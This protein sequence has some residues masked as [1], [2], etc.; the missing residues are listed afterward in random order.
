MRTN[1][2]SARSLLTRSVIKNICEFRWKS[3]WSVIAFISV[4]IG[5]LMINTQ[6][7]AAAIRIACRAERKKWREKNP[8]I[9]KDAR[10][11][12]EHI[13]G[14]SELVHT[15]AS[16]RWLDD[17]TIACFL[18]DIPYA[19]LNLSIH[20]HWNSVLFHWLIH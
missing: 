4:V 1:K 15:N 20:R 9:E 18:F 12:S 10:K 19:W 7:H 5:N 8:E 2:E 16:C 14:E 6:T 17:C 3:V 13:N 11:K